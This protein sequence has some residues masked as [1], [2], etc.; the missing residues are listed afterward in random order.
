ML[1]FQGNVGALENHTDE[2]EDYPEGENGPKLIRE[3]YCKLTNHMWELCNGPNYVLK[4]GQCFRQ[5]CY[6]CKTKFQQ[7]TQPTTNGDGDAKHTKKKIK[8][9]GKYWLTFKNHVQ[10]CVHCINLACVLLVGQNSLRS[11]VCWNTQIAEAHKSRKKEYR[12]VWS[13]RSP[14][15]FSVNILS[16]VSLSVGDLV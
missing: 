12:K 15:V 11:R 9:E 14:I 8:V 4:N 2:D 7:G 16:V 5:S 1:C 13:M 3:P 6:L 10:H